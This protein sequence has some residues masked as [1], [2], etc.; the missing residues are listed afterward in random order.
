MLM[1]GLLS[2]GLCSC[3]VARFTED[4]SADRFTT[5][6]VL[7]NIA[8]SETSGEPPGRSSVGARSSTIVDASSDLPTNRTYSQRRTQVK[9]GDN[10]ALIFQREGIAARELQRLLAS[11]PLGARLK[12]IFPG[13]EFTFT[14]A[15]DRVLVK[16]NYSPGPLEA[17]EFV[18]IGN[19]FVGRKITQQPETTTAFKHATIDHSLL[20]KSL[21]M[22]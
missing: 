10:L 3:V 15:E 5:E 1:V 2:L 14:L 11:K 17:L 19:D 20:Q 4:D 21:K 13:H 8:S 6:A 18:R 16:L 7:L 12:N 9:P 22:I